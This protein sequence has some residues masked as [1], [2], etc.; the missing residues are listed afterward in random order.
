MRATGVTTWVLGAIMA[1]LP[2]L[3][4]TAE[5]KI[6]TVQMD[7]VVRAYP[8]AQKAEET[9]KAQKDEFE[10]EIEKLEAKAVEMR[11][12]VEAA[13]AEA[14]D[15][16][17]NE[18]ERDRR[19][20]VARQK[21]K[22]LTEY[23]GKVRE[24]RLDRQK[25]LSDQEMRIFRRVM[26]QLRDIVAE[27]ATEQKLDLVLDEAGVGMHGAPLVAYAADSLDI[28]EAILKRLAAKPAG[29]AGE[30]GDGKADEK[31]PADGKKPE[32]GKGK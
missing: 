7:K 19:A 18:T 11:T 8:E 9:L 25:E 20:E 2:A 22:V 28:T 5:L 6:A 17:I 30:K 13:V 21:I 27:Y 31:K 32:P 3:S 1:V 29:A 14:Q 26:G 24:T 4:A 10:K 12:A 23:Q 15:K 16:A